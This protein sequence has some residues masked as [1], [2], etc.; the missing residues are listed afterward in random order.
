MRRL[1]S[2]LLC[3]YLVFT[4]S[5]PARAQSQNPNT[6]HL[7]LYGLQTS[8]FP[9]ISA[10]LDVFDSAGNDVTGLKPNSVTL[11]EDNKP[12]PLTLLQEVKVGV[13]FALALDPGPTFAFRDA[14]AVTRY[15]KIVQILK[16][17][18]ASHSDSLGDD[19]S[20]VPT[21]GTLSAHMTS[22]A[23]FLDAL[24]AYLPNL[25]SITPSLNT[26]SSALDTVS[27]LT[28]T[29]GMKKTVLYVTSPTAVDAIPTLQNLTERAVGLQVRVNVWIVASTDF[30]SSSGAT[31]LKDLAI[32]TGG[33][34]VLFSGV[35]PLPGLET[36]FAPLRSTYQLTYNSGILSPGGHTLAA[37]TTLDG[38]TVS[39]APLSFSLDI[40][41]PNPML[42]APP[43]QIVRQAPDTHTTATTA[44]LPN[45]QLIV[46][47]VEFPDGRT[48]PL[49]STTLFVDNQKVAENTAEPFD[50]FSWDLSGYATS[51]QHILSVEAVDSLGLSK[52]SL[53]VPVM[54]TV[55]KPQFGLLPF[56]SRNSPWVALIAI[57]FAGA[58]LGV[59]LSGGRFKRSGR[60]A[61]QAATIDPLTQPVEGETG[62]HMRVPWKRPARQS[63]AYLERL[64]EDGQPMSAPAIP[65]LAPEMTF[66]SDPMQVTRILDDPSVS[67]LHARLLQQAGEYILSDEKSVAGTWVNYDLL[68]AP[69]RLQHGDLLQFGRLSY[70]FMLRTPPELSRPKT[71][72]TK[73]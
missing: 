9:A 26:L 30:F 16:S 34:Y 38:A 51:G 12:R 8:N 2:V 61:D 39:S 40:E 52:T 27:E 18:I 35:E 20:L 53:G 21:Y 49:V 36:Y 15:D 70:R 37:Q 45:Q 56:L 24:A 63:D 42:V 32:Q 50:H 29:A 33:Q 5:T 4:G 11:L 14:N 6:A 47:I 31:A 64:R 58:V 1:L 71:T 17:W 10:G 66:G 23:A 28:S 13:E 57:I 54:V 62:R 43:D 69:R 25:N 46:I 68:A 55:I 67:P 60:L 44:F 22:T 73:V 3:V 41:P 48:R 65:V 19:L 7:S 72:P 59:I